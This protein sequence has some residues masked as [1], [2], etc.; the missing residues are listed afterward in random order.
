MNL[1]PYE[2][3]CR[4]IVRAQGD[5]SDFHANGVQLTDARL[6]AVLREYDDAAPE[7]V[8]DMLEQLCHCLEFGA[9][10]SYVQLFGSK[11]PMEAIGVAL[12]AGCRNRLLARFR[13]DLQSTASELELEDAT[14]DE[15][16]RGVTV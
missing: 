1:S 3:L 13:K 4:D 12:I 8:G 11:S 5:A 9:N 16:A 14:D 10:S 6:A 15:H 2:A 7:V